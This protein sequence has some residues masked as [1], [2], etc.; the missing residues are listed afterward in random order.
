[1]ISLKVNS[2]EYGY[3]LRF[4][5]EHGVYANY[6]AEMSKNYDSHSSFYTVYHRNYS[7]F[8]NRCSPQ[9]WLDHCFTWNYTIKGD[10]FW[11]HLDDLWRN[12]YYNEIQWK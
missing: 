8:F 10:N 12:K 7:E 1:M 11:S 9:N 3:F 5:K 6:F 4:L 2:K